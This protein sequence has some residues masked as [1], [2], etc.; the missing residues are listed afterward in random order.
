MLARFKQRSWCVGGRRTA[1]EAGG[2]AGWLLQGS[3]ATSFAREG[4][5]ALCDPTRAD[6]CEGKSDPTCALTQRGPGITA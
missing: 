1:A 2:T 6:R 4:R 5:D 3:E